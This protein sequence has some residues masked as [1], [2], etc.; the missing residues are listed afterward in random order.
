MT[1]LLPCHYT[2]LI[3]AV[4]IPCHNEVLHKL[5]N[6]MAMLTNHTSTRPIVP[7]YRSELHTI[8]NA[9]TGNNRNITLNQIM[10][11]DLD[12]DR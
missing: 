3:S 5:C 10:D 4:I 6:P 9:Y 8:I 11:L 1:N 12:L 2:S 7:N